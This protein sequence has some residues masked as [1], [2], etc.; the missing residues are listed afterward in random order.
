MTLVRPLGMI[1]PDAVATISTWPKVAQAS[2]RQNRAMSVTPIA[3]ASGGGG[4]STISRAAGRKASSSSVR[5]AGLCRYATRALADFMD[6][7]LQTV[8][9]RVAAAGV[10]QLVVSAVLGGLPTSSSRVPPQRCRS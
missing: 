9:R 1:L 3:P 4:V 10:D 6:A 8:Q 2:A 7:C 5:D